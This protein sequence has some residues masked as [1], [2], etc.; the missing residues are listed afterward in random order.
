MHDTVLGVVLS[1]AS[2]TTGVEEAVVTETT[3]CCRR[4]VALSLLTLFLLL[5][6]WLLLLLR[7]CCGSSGFVDTGVSA[8]TG[9]ETISVELLLCEV[10]DC[11]S[12][13]AL[14]VL[15]AHDTAEVE[16]VDA[17]TTLS[18]ELSNNGGF[19]LSG[20]MIL[21]NIC[22]KLIGESLAMSSAVSEDVA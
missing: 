14:S 20:E 10:S 1:T 2:F 4:A 12:V 15:C 11:T 22:L 3:G 6:W 5:L 21:S 13:A 9:A 17:D 18:N 19:S 7:C 16:A 8:T